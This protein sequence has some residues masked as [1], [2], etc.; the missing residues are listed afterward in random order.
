MI[1]AGTLLALGVW[2]WLDGGRNLFF[3]KNWGVVEE[4]L[5]YRS[6][7]IHRRIVKDVLAEHGIR[8]VVDLAGTDEADPNFAPEREAVRALGIHLTTFRH[9]D[10]YGLGSMDDY[11]AAFG[12]L[13]RARRDKQ[14]ILVH[15]GGGSE[16][17]GAVFA[18]YRMLVDGWDGA[19]AYDEYVHYRHKQ[20]T[21]P[22]LQTF[23]NKG[24]GRIAKAMRSEHLLDT[25]PDPLP[26]FGP[27]GSKQP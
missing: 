19:R 14:P 6:G 8:V 22:A 4:G 23:V 25:V 17:T 9:L 20:P 27:A 2:W 15:C 16:R 3:P 12:I 26:V 24:L 18:W 5:V 10:G 7:R 11:L 13:L 1:L 21:S